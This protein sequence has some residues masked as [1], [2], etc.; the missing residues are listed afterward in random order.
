MIKQL[1]TLDQDFEPQF[2]KLVARDASV[3]P[4]IKQRAEAIV[5]DVAARG[6]EAVIEYTN[7]F[8][9]LNLKTM[10]DAIVTREEMLQA[11]ETLPADQKQA[12]ETA[13]KRI[14]EF[15]EHQLEKG[16][17]IT[18]SYGSVLGQRITA[19]D[20]V[21][22]YVPGGKAAYP[23]SVLMN[24]MP[25]HVAGVPRIEMV[26]PTPGGERNQ[27]VLAAA[28][29][30]GVS[31][32]FT[33]GGAQAVAALAF[34][35]ES[36]PRVDKITGPGNIFVANAKREVFGHVGIDMV[37]GPSE[38]LVIADDSANPRY[39]AADLLSQAEHDPLAAAILVTDSE[40]L[41]TAVQA[42]IAHQTALLPR[43]DVIEKS[44]TAYGTIVIAPTLPDCA[45]IANQIAPEHMELSVADPYGLLPLIEN[46]GAIFL[47]HYSP[48]PLGDYLAGPNHVL[49][50]SGTARFF[51]PLSVDDFVKKSSLICC[52]RAELERVSEQVMLLAR[53][54]G[55]D[56]HAN[57]VA[58]RFGKEIKA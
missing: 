13:A 9:H 7:R 11:L 17:T 43:R 28:A 40:A 30:A 4:E 45:D 57:A 16:W 56:A 29:L 37:A 38:V 32:A 42:E 18:D 14:R 12:L 27:L 50:T 25:A 48:E 8:D 54:E 35:T 33:I 51:S 34:G 15:H 26:F 58:I 3:D 21:G 41:A 49:P 20:S 31:R 46:A 55:L 53:Q 23:S 2:E 1:S 10:E 5:Q 22:L 39:V 52:S 24:A 44:L 36:I 19:I 6:D 47:G